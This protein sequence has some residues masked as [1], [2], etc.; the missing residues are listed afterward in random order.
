MII[1]GSDQTIGNTYVAAATVVVRWACR[2]G[3]PFNGLYV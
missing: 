3:A 2:G 1:Y